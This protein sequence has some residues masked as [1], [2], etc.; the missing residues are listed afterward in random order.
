MKWLTVS[1][2]PFLFDPRSLCLFYVANAIYVRA[3]AW[4]EWISFLSFT[5]MTPEIPATF[6]AVTRTLMPYVI[7]LVHL[8]VSLSL[9]HDRNHNIPIAVPSPT[10]VT[11]GNSCCPLRRSVSVALVTNP[12]AGGITSRRLAQSEIA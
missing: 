6:P 7:I 3:Y 5:P 12:A 1:H 11:H 8:P 9:T 4:P 2:Y 10:R